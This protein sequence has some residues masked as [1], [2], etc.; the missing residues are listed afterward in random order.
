MDTLDMNSITSNASAQ[1][2]SESSKTSFPA[3]SLAKEL[4]CEWGR[5]YT[6]CDNRH[7]FHLTFIFKSPDNFPTRLH[8]E[9]EM[10]VDIS[11][12]F[13]KKNSC[14]VANAMFV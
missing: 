9:I 8:I 14:E 12:S 10:N 1:A 13:L 7:L 3:N 6:T 2:V 5:E 4:S 11:L